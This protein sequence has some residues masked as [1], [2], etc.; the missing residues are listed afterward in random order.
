MLEV[1]GE[2]RWYYNAI[3]L[4]IG[5]GDDE[6]ALCLAVSTDGVHWTRKNVGVYEFN[7][8]KDNNIIM[9]GV[10]TFFVDPTE[11]RG[12]RFK[13]VMQGESPT[14][15]KEYGLRTCHSKDGSAGRRPRKSPFCLFRATRRTSASTTRG[16]GNTWP[17]FGPGIRNGCA[18]C[19]GSRWKI[20]ISRR[21][22]M[23]RLS[24]RRAGCGRASSRKKLPIVLHAD[25]ADPPQTDL[26]TPSVV[27]YPWAADAYFAFPS[28]YRHYDGLDSHG[29]DHRGKNPNDGP[30]AIQMAA[31]RSRGTQWNRFRREYVSPGLIG[32][33]DGGSIY[34]NVG[35]IRRGDYIYQYYSGYPFT[36]GDYKFSESYNQSALYRLVQRLDGFVSADAGPEGGRIYHP[37]DCFEGN[38]LQL[39]I[40]CGAMGEAWAEIF[41]A[42]GGRIDGFTLDEAISVDRNGTAQ[43]VWWK[44]GP[45]FPPGGKTCPV[46]Y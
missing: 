43:D 13:G 19:P 23:R 21:G 26:Y 32:E 8:S 25:E 36:H 4:N 15:S 44:G 37:A 31:S 20:F 39:N 7:G 45:T 35:M 6:F 14:R 16:S 3:P 34:M 30:T 27:Q 22:R 42:D 9:R 11:S 2:Y 24:K 28:P 18:R 5:G 29:R 38:R 46:A 17:T 33:G 1:D 40:N 12:Y 41:D 10:A